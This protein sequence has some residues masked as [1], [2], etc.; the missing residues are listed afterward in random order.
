MTVTKMLNELQSELSG[1]VTEN[2]VEVLLHGMQLGF[3]FSSSYRRN[4]EDF[5]A[6]YFFRTADDRLNLAA[7]FDD[8]KMEVGKTAP[9]KWNVRVTFR[10]VPALQKFLFSR[11]HDILNS[12]LANE[13]DVDGNLNYIYKFGFMARELGLKLGVF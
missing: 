11:D 1:A 6:S 9:D 7:I 13:V 8:G 2:F 5:K 12:L 4:I 10:N 3:V